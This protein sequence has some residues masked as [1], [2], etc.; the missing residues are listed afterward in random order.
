ML[1]MW[2]FLKV[3]VPAASMLLLAVFQYAQSE[4]EGA[5]TGLHSG[6]RLGVGL[7]AGALS[8]KLEMISRDLAYL[9]SRRSLATAFQGADDASL[10]PQEDDFDTFAR[11]HQDYDQFRW[12]D[13]S[14]MERVRVDNRSDGPKVLQKPDLQDKG[15]RYF[16]TDSIKLDPGAVFISPL[17]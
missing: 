9:A 14:G 3:F 1:S 6:E 11:A 13:E 17:A 2:R 12:I 16:F 15:K 4:I 7:G 8:G 5:L 10:A